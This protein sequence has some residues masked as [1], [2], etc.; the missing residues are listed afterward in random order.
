M[1]PD[2]LPGI[3][4]FVRVARLAS[5]TRAAAELGVS[6][7]AVSQTIRSLERQLGVR[8]LDRSTRRVGVTEAGRRF[9]EDA[10]PALEALNHAVL[11]L[12]ESREEASGTLR[13]N[14]SRVAAEIL[15]RPHI[16]EFSARWPDVT[17]DLSCDNRM[18]DLVDG[19]FDAGIRLGESL[20]QDVVALPLGGP[21]TMVTVAAP[22]YLA[23]RRPPLTPD[24]LAAHSCV[25]LRMSSGRMY[26]WEYV[27]ADGSPFEVEVRGPVVS[28]DNGLLLGAVRA[29]AGIGCAFEAEAAEW[30]ADG[31]LVPLLR[32][33]WPTFSGFH[34]YYPSRAQMPRKLRVFIDFMQ[35]RLAP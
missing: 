1:T 32:P 22:A 14:L 18:L 15:L 5:F 3:A 30:L 13:L 7:S 27:A 20:A 35:A 24:D 2:L 29:G 12:D 9:L 31:S 33:W 16:A 17:L 6:P 21:L 11:Q 28:N 19:G 10:A 26:R 23:G 8:L 34:L 25:A 4:A